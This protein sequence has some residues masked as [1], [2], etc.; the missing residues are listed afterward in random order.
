MGG[1]VF[2]R[3]RPVCQDNWGRN[4]AR[5]LCKSRGYQTGLPTK[6]SKFGPVPRNFVKITCR[7]YEARLEDCSITIPSGLA[8]C[9]IEESAGVICSNENEDG[10][11]GIP[12]ATA[13]SQ[14]GLVIF[15][16]ALTVLLG[17]A[18]WKRENIRDF[19]KREILIRQHGE[20]DGLLSPEYN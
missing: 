13:G 20:A 9:D 2:Y 15:L 3:G 10:G 5:I 12:P 8:S 14:A 4:E 6:E 11:D 18:T 16:I 19:V 1:N 17:L 7:G